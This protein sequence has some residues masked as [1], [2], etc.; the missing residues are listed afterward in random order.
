MLSNAAKVSL[1]FLLPLTSTGVQRIQKELAEIA[2]DPPGTVLHN[3][4]CAPFF[5][6]FFVARRLVLAANISAGPKTPDNLFEW[7]STI[8]GP[9]GGV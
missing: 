3:N 7:V 2:V 6:R 4:V 1:P 9:E 8:M 5:D